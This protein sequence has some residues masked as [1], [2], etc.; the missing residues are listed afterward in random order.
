[1][2]NI[3]ALRIFSVNYGDIDEIVQT[4]S[5]IYSRLIITE[6]INPYQHYHL[7]MWSDKTLKQVK[8][9]MYNHIRAPITVRRSRNNINVQVVENIPAYEKYIKKDFIR[10]FDTR[11]GWLTHP[12]EYELY[13]FDNEMTQEEQEQYN[14]YLQHQENITGYIH[15]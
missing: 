14:I 3:Y 6:E 2:T 13:D 11:Y 10:G 7:M 12:K 4:F 9:W 15:T 5:K 1:M 8:K